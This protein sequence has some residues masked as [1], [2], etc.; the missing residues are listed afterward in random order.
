MADVRASHHPQQAGMV[1][2]PYL[3]AV[4]MVMEGPYVPRKYDTYTHTQQATSQPPPRLASQPAGRPVIIIVEPPE[5]PAPCL[6]ACLA[7]WLACSLAYLVSQ[8]GHD[9]ASEQRLVWRV[10]GGQESGVCRHED[11]GARAVDVMQR[12]A[13]VLQALE[14]RLHQHSH[15]P[16]THTQAAADFLPASHRQVIGG[17]SQ[18]AAAPHPPAALPAAGCACSWRPCPGC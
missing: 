9:L 7:C 6:P 4:S 8:R 10:G 11:A 12:D 18:Q 2:G 1:V 16:S 5:L 13:G 3:Q 15:Q 17:P 14:H